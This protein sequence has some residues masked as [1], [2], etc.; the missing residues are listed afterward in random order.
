MSTMWPGDND[1]AEVAEAKD[2]GQVQMLKVARTGNMV[3]I[4][5]YEATCAKYSTLVLP[6]LYI[7]NASNAANGDQMLKIKGHVMTHCLN[8]R[9]NG[10][11]PHKAVAYKVLTLTDEPAEDIVK[12]VNISWDFLEGVRKAYESDKSSKVLVHC[13]GVKDGGKLSRSS[14]VLIGYLMKLD[15]KKYKLAAKQ[16]EIARQKQYQK[17][18]VPNHG[19]I[20]QLKKMYKQSLKD[21]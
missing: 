3:S 5:H 11:K 14:A 18:C 12:Q 6:W 9:Q 20:Q 8:C 2:D 7:G 17:M 15:K 21:C 19:F 13:D 4:F 16:L 1:F 10:K